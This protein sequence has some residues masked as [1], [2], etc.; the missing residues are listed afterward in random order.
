MIKELENKLFFKLNSFTNLYGLFLLKSILQLNDNGRAAYIVPSEFLNSDYGK[1]I[2]AY[3]IQSKT[4]RHIIVIHFEDNIFTEAIT[5]ACILL[6]ANDKQSEWVKFSAIHSISELEKLQEWL[7]TYPTYSDKMACFNFNELNPDIKWRGYYQEKNS[8]KYKSL[9]AF[10]NYA[11]AKRGI[12]TGANQPI[13][14]KI[15]LL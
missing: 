2:K 6:L 15:F 12:A 9:V 7:V 14:N 8:I 5:T 4:L 1:Q 13:S 11:K 10:S 3:L